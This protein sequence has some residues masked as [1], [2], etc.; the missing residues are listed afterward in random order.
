MELTITLW[1]V[2]WTDNFYRTKVK[3]LPGI[4]ETGVSPFFVFFK[5]DIKGSDENEKPQIQD[6][7]CG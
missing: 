3:G 1:S 4:E 7:L 2:L 5:G 6:Q